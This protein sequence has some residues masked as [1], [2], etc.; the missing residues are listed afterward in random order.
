MLISALISKHIELFQNLNLLGLRAIGD[1]KYLIESESAGTSYDV[2]D[3]IA[4][5]DVV[6]EKIAFGLTILH[7]QRL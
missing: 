6:K 1:E 4:F 5:A 2:S 3:V 7:Q